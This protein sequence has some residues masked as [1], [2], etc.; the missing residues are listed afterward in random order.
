MTIGELFRAL[1]IENQSTEAVYPDGSKQTDTYFL[2]IMLEGH[3][4]L[5]EADVE[6]YIVHRGSSFIK[7]KGAEHGRRDD[8]AEGGGFH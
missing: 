7:A 5:L 8:T 3:G 6:N 2:H 1:E 4:N